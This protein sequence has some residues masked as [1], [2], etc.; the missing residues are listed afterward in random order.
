[1]I[2]AVPVCAHSRQAI[3]SR[4]TPD[5]GPEYRIK[6]AFPCCQT[7]V[8]YGP[9]PDHA[10]ALTGIQDATDSYTDRFDDTG[11]MEPPERK[12]RGCDD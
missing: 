2:D 3:S 7:I 6:P 11:A 1:M 9:C 8:Y 4:R 5:H 10:F 12:R